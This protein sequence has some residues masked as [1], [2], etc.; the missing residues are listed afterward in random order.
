MKLR[1]NLKAKTNVVVTQVA[2]VVIIVGIYNA[3]GIQCDD[4]DGG[5]TCFCNIV[6]NFITN[7]NKFPRKDPN[8]NFEFIIGFN[9]F[10]TQAVEDA[11]QL[12]K[13]R[14]KRR[15]EIRW[16]LGDTLAL[17]VEIEYINCVTLTF[18]LY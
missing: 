2:F 6:S 15:K 4:Y 1:D 7:L 5:K 12:M 10:R 14:K 9:D 17:S 11:R 3:G 13:R 18:S 8:A 16:P